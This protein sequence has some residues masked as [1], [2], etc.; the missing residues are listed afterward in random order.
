[1]RSSTVQKHEG[2][3]SNFYF[4]I[5]T[6]RERLRYFFMLSLIPDKAHALA[7]EWLRPGCFL[8]KRVPYTEVG[9]YLSAADIGLLFRDQSWTNRVAAPTKF[10]EHAYSGLPI[11]ITGGIGDTEEYVR[12]IGSGVIIDSAKKVPDTSSL[13][14]LLNI[15]REDSSQTG[16]KE[17][18]RSRWLNVLE[19]EYTLLATG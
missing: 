5:S 4:L 19:R 15:D 13:H 10:S 3:I 14:Q 9:R 2:Q 16:L 8:V 1:M 12:T 17:Y 6:F 18:G 7:T 11:C